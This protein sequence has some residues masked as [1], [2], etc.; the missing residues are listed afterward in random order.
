MRL[1]A[2][3]PKRHRVIYAAASV[4]LSYPDEGVL[5]ATYAELA[6]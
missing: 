5:E 4:V 2:P 3:P 1:P 6:G